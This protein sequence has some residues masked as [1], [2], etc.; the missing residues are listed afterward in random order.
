METEVHLMPSH[1]SSSE[2]IS[3]LEALMAGGCFCVDPDKET[4]T[5]KHYKKEKEYTRTINNLPTL[6]FITDEPMAHET[7]FYYFYR[8]YG[9]L[10][11]KKYG[12]KM[13]LKK[14]LERFHEY[15]NDKLSCCANTSAAISDVIATLPKEKVKQLDG[16]KNADRMHYFIFLKL[17][18]LIERNKH[19]LAMEEA[20]IEQDFVKFRNAC[21]KRTWIDY[22]PLKDFFRENKMIKIPQQ[23]RS[24]SEFCSFIDAQFLGGNFEITKNGLRFNHF[25]KNKSFCWDMQVPPSHIKNSNFDHLCSLLREIHAKKDHHGFLLLLSLIPHC[26]RKGLI[27]VKDFLVSRSQFE[28]NNKKTLLQELKAMTSH[29]KMELEGFDITQQ[30]DSSYCDWYIDRY[31]ETTKNS[32]ELDA[33]KKEN[34]QDFVD[35][36]RR[37]LRINYI[38]LKDRLPQWEAAVEKLQSDYFL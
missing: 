24:L 33:V 35:A 11:S 8:D 14:Q 26:Q 5:F 19:R 12:K 1:P 25:K 38:P 17:P 2:I 37:P 7:T 28:G 3:F 31:L 32:S 6:E 20:L 23:C 16:V 34:L 9:L 4:I 13:V 36:S 18:A 15:A 30:N 10:I 27:V 29:E 22:E 21:W